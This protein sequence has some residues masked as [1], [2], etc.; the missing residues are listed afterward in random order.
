MCNLYAFMSN[1]EAVRNFVDDFEDKSGNLQHYPGIYPDYA[2]PI[3]RNVD[4]DRELVTHVRWG[5]PSSRDAILKAA[6][7]RAAKLDAKGKAYDF[8]APLKMEPDGG[9]TNIRNSCESASK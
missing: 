2:A 6:Q 9:T 4:R 8:N 7:K 3:I 1:Q 5:M